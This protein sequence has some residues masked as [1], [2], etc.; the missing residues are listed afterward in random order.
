[1]AYTYEKGI[2]IKSFLKKTKCSYSTET[3]RRH[4]C[5]FSSSSKVHTKVTGSEGRREGL[6]T[7]PVSP[8]SPGAGAQPSLSLGT[9]GGAWLSAAPDA[10]SGLDC[11][12]PRGPLK[13]PVT[14]G[15]VSLWGEPPPTTEDGEWGWRGD[16]CTDH[17][18]PRTAGSAGRLPHGGRRHQ[19]PAQD[20]G[21]GGRDRIVST[22]LPER[23][24]L[25]M[26]SAVTRTRETEPRTSRC[27][28]EESQV[29]CTLGEMPSDGPLRALTASTGAGFRRNGSTS[30][31]SSSSAGP[32]SG[33]ASSSRS[34]CMLRAVS[35]QMP[36]TSSSSGLPDAPGAA[37]LTA[38]EG[39]RRQDLPLQGLGGRSLTSRCSELRAGASAPERGA[40]ATLHAEGYLLGGRDKA[41]CASSAP[42]TRR[43]TRTDGAPCR[44][45]PPAGANRGADGRRLAGAVLTLSRGREHPHSDVFRRTEVRDVG[46]APRRWARPGQ[47]LFLPRPTEAALHTGRAPR[48][49][50]SGD[51]RWSFPRT[52]RCTLGHD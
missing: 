30:W 40:R 31:K 21:D 45:R 48:V 29:L 38:G 15:G 12:Q 47:G 11:K 42:R 19:R 41:T 36:P 22:E 46:D 2:K 1:M 44:R 28:Y 9:Q 10:R 51:G 32:W 17:R 14:Q 4:P 7:S 34:V 43:A 52:L 23:P 50:A 6:C 33:S 3:R 18:P 8:V 20:C 25:L 26:V 5:Y 37:G 27:V 49:T 39:H 35:Q 16:G 13:S 24:V